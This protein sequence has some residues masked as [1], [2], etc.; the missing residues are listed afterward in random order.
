M[1]LMHHDLAEMQQR[2]AERDAKYHERFDRM[3]G[4]VENLTATAEIHERR[5]ERLEEGK[6]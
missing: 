2:E 5:I 4:L 6:A 3:L 1:E